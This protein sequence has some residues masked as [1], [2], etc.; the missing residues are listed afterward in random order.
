MRMLRATIR[1]L[2][3]TMRILRATIRMLRAT[4]R[5]L[6]ATRA[7]SAT[8][9]RNTPAQPPHAIHAGD[10]AGGPPGGSSGR[11]PGG[12]GGANGEH[13]HRHAGPAA[14]TNNP[15]YPYHNNAAHTPSR[16][17]VPLRGG[18]YPG[19]LSGG[20]YAV[21]TDVFRLGRGAGAGSTNQEWQKETEALRARGQELEARHAQAVR[22]AEEVRRQLEARLAEAEAARAA[23]RAAMEERKEQVAPSRPPLDPL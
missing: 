23:E 16:F 6:R 2:R 19:L 12:E 11:A 4:M 22:Q 10:V 21:A 1:M 7:C 9:Q 17:Q 14:H 13:S 15:Y 8:H 3:A 5:M 18:A 20:H